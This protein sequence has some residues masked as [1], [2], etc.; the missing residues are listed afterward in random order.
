MWSTI[1]KEGKRVL[2]RYLNVEK[3]RSVV[4]PNDIDELGEY[5]FSNK[6]ALNLEAIYIPDHIVDIPAHCF[7]GNKATY[8]RLSPKTEHIGDGAFYNCQNLWK[9]TV[10][11]DCKLG[12]KRWDG[13]W[14][15]SA[16]VF[17]NCP[18]H[19]TRFSPWLHGIREQ[20]Y[21][22]ILF[23]GPEGS[24]LQSSPNNRDW[25]DLP[26]YKPNLFVADDSGDQIY[27][28]VVAPNTMPTKRNPSK[29]IAK[30]KIILL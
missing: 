14:A 1:N 9:A 11:P 8:I 30:T 5:A 13:T 10:P 12:T 7:A 20:G 26:F 25:T 17:E 16:S 28:R 4:V 23:E 6:D 18:K 15:N 21:V 27:Y 19:A 2:F 22:T 24:I 3:V 29:W